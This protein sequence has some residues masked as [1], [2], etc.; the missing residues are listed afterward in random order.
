MLANRDY[1]PDD[2]T[3]ERD[4][5]AYQREIRQAQSAGIDG[6]A[7]NVGGWFQEPRYIR[8]ASD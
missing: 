6:F 7:L 2:P 8:R 5:A 3:G 4:I 1:T